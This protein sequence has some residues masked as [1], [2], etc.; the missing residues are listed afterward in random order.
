[1]NIIAVAIVAAACY[2]AGYIHGE[3]SLAA[4]LI[5]QTEIIYKNNERTLD[6]EIPTK[7]LI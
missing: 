4:R 3:W 7:K 2:T 5:N 6:R 1:M